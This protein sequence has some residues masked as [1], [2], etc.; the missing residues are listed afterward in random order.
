MITS[1][2]FW[3][4]RETEE[5]AILVSPDPGQASVAVTRAAARWR[6]VLANGEE[7]EVAGPPTRVTPTPMVRYAAEPRRCERGVL[8]SIDC[9]EQ[10]T[11]EGTAT[12]LRILDEELL[13]VGIAHAELVDADAW[14][15]TTLQPGSCLTSV[16][17]EQH[18]DAVDLR[19]FIAL[20]AAE[21]GD[22][23]RAAIP[24]VSAGPPFRS[25]VAEFGVYDGVALGG[26][27]LESW[28]CR[29]DLSPAAAT[30]LRSALAED[31]AT[32]LLWVVLYTGERVILCTS[33]EG[34]AGVRIRADLADPIKARL[35]DV[36][37]RSRV[38]A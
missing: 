7:L 16:E 34:T 12:I 29:F 31:A 32:R 9:E 27:L 10:A 37:S 38:R 6:Y 22:G 4:P 21:I 24:Y 33:A 18:D 3:H 17:A 1:A 13:R 28:N 2:G 36:V 30:A 14:D 8:V 20:A 23:V 11:R 35:A 19:A 25:F 26:M 15:T 5:D